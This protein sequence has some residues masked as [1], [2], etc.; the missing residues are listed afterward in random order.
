MR[1]QVGTASSKQN[2]R[3]N[4]VIRR[5]N[6]IREYKYAFPECLQSY[7]VHVK[8]VGANDNCGYRVIASTLSLGEHYWP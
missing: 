2:K 5:S 4:E 7:I 6:K 8:N 3:P 1:G